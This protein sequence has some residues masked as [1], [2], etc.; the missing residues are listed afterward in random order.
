MNNV[1]HLNVQYDCFRLHLLPLQ[2]KQKQN[3]IPI[4]NNYLTCRYRID[5]SRLSVSLISEIIL[6]RTVCSLFEGLEMKKEIKRL[7]R[8]RVLKCVFLIRIAVEMTR[9]DK[10][11]NR[12]SLEFSYLV[13]FVRSFF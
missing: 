3:T 4:K 6:P 2:K 10:R 1:Y 7:S 13:V 11:S 5:F 9:P 12:N 8:K